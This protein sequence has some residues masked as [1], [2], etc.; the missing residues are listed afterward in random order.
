[1]LRLLLKIA[2]VWFSVS[3]LCSF[4]WALLALRR[5]ARQAPRP[6]GTSTQA[7][8]GKEVEALLATPAASGPVGTEP[9]RQGTEGGQVRAWKEPAAGDDVSRADPFRRERAT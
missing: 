3:L 8:S 4:L 7:L 5:R 9:A 1:M 6:I 2:V